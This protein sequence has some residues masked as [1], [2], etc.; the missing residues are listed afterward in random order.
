MPPPAVP[1]YPPPPQTLWPPYSPY[2]PVAP[3]PGTVIVPAPRPG[4]GTFTTIPGLETPHWDLTVDALWLERDVG[5]SVGLGYIANGSGGSGHYHFNPD[6]IYTDDVCLPLEAGVR[7]QLSRRISDQAAIEASYW[8]LQ[9][10]SVGEPLFADPD[11]GL[12]AYSPWL[13][14]ASATGLNNDVSYTYSSQVHNAE[15]NERILLSAY[16]PYWAFGWLWGVRYFNLSDNFTLSGSGLD[17]GYSESLNYRTT[18]NLIGPQLGLQCVR[19]WDRFQ[20]ITEGKIGLMANFS[21]QQGSDVAGG[22]PPGFTPMDSSH[23]DTD[24]SALFELSITA[25]FRVSQYLWLRAAYQFYAVTGL[26]LGPRQLGGADH[27]GVVG[28]D[29]LSLGLETAW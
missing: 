21:T 11:H 16:G 28:L 2:G 4:P 20:L 27:N 18:N 29:G 10:W 1:Y 23:S 25:R 12:L 8:G 13:Q 7:F 19:G 22:N 26:A 14:I 3:P 15:I 24:F 6:A 5:N 17:T 9:Q